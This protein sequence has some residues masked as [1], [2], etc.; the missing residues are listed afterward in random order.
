MNRLEAVDR[1]LQANL[2]EHFEQ[3]EDEH[4][5]ICSNI[6]ITPGQKSPIAKYSIQKTSDSSI[7]L[8]SE[9]ESDSNTVEN[10]CESLS[11][12][13]GYFGLTQHIKIEENTYVTNG[14]CEPIMQSTPIAGKSENVVTEK[15]CAKK[16]I[17]EVIRNLK[18]LKDI[19]HFNTNE[20]DLFKLI[21]TLDDFSV[22][23]K[24]FTQKIL[25]NKNAFQ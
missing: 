14:M 12:C 19:V 4:C 11:E 8:E 23:L 5:E 1:L 25:L 21:D 16:T 3:C 17:D 9:I 18:Y 6:D 13:S 10:S 22:L 7:N 15:D 24:K 2:L 20:Y